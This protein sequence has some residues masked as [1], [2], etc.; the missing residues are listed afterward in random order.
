M[1]VNDCSMNN[2][3]N[4]DPAKTRVREQARAIYTQEADRRKQDRLPSL[5]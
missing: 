5:I 4:N 3:L 2:K 1:T